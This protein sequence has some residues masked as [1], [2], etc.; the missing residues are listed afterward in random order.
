MSR[1]VAFAY[2]V[3]LIYQIYQLLIFRTQPNAHSTTIYN[4][5][6]SRENKIIIRQA[7]QN[8]CV[9]RSSTFFLN[10]FLERQHYSAKKPISHGVVGAKGGVL[11]CR[12]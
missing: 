10:I 6:L 4:H 7:T 9:N 1:R 8:D 5:T 11:N 2:Q 3:L 12:L